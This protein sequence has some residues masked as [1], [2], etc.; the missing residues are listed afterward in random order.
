[1]EE[2]DK[3][4]DSILQRLKGKADTFREDAAGKLA[5]ITG[6]A[7]EEV[8]QRLAEVNDIVP[9]IAELGYS[10][11]G[12]TLGLGLMP[13][14]QLKISGL[15]RTMPEGTYRRV[16]E[17]HRDRAMLIAVVKALQTASETHQRIRILGMHSD[18]ASLTLGLPPKVSLEFKKNE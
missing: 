16:L 3:P 5:E 13:D 8:R 9:L 4:N 6:A 17:E 10:L 15:S 12:I 11:D 18:N 1:M 2:G 7:G 14:I